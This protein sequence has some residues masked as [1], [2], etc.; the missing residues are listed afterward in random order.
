MTGNNWRAD[1]PVPTPRLRLIAC[2]ALARALLAI[3]NQL[4]PDVVELA[5]LPAA[6][7][8]HLEKI[9]PG[10]KVKVKAARKAGRTPVVIYGD[11]GTGGQLD[12]FLDEQNIQQIR[13]PRC[14]HSFM[15]D[16]G[17]DAA[18]DEKLR[19]FF[20]TDHMTRHFER[21]VMKGMVLRDHPQLH[22]IYFAHYKRVL[23]IAQTDDAA[24]VEKARQAAATL[25]LEYGY[26]YTG[27]GDYTAFLQNLCNRR[28]PSIGVR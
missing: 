1:P 12:A 3:I 20:L 23:Y 5:C 27:S 6:S 24:L 9:V 10:L 4:P 21:I 14:Y 26:H 2:R 22:D 8:N 13:G 11:C 28:Q 16:A 15:G 7:H 18:M 17:F 19:T 25:Q